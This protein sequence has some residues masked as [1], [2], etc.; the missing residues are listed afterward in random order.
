MSKRPRWPVAEHTLLAADLLNRGRCPAAKA[1]CGRGGRVPDGEVAAEEDLLRTPVLVH[2]AHDQE[3]RR[4][5]ARE[6]AQETVRAKLTVQAAPGGLGSRHAVAKS[7]RR[8]SDE[9]GRSLRRDVRKRDGRRGRGG[10]K[11]AMG[12]RRRHRVLRWGAAAFLLTSVG[13]PRGCRCRLAV[14]GR[15]RRGA[16]GGRRRRHRRRWRLCT[17][18]W[19]SF[20][21]HVGLHGSAVRHDTAF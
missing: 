4:S 10:K 2:P 1:C 12:R 16:R 6:P 21:Q 20:H 9:L 14:S 13:R 11:R 8:R 3:V 7:H 17:A 18:L 19:W 5:C 15:R